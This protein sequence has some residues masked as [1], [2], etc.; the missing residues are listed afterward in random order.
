MSE[1]NTP[2]NE[3]TKPTI[4]EVKVRTMT[5]TQSQG[6]KIPSADQILLPASNE[7]SIDGVHP[8]LISY[9]VHLAYIHWLLFGKPLII[10]SG[11][12]GKHVAGSLHAQGR[13]L[14][15]RT[16]DLEADEELVFFQVLA[17]SAVGRKCGVFDERAVPGGA[18]IH[19]EYHG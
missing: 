18:H 2:H 11:K 5:T 14:D 10:T 16:R 4:A 7:V 8:D 19:V 1:D 9:A 17:F 12:D 15:F 3:Y 6:T 13:A